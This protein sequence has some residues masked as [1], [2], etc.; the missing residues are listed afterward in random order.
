MGETLIL[1]QQGDPVVVEESV[2]FIGI[3]SAG[4]RDAC[5]RLVFPAVTTPELPPLVYS[6]FG[7]CGNPT[8]TLNLDN[9][10]LR[11]P[12]VSRTLTLGGTRVTRFE[13]GEGDVIVT[14]IW[15]GGQARA[16]LT[17]A[18]FRQFYDYLA[19]SS[20]LGPTDFITWEPRDRNANVYQVELLSLTVGSGDADSHFDVQDFRDPGGLDDGGSIA[21]ALDDANVLPTGYVDREMELRMRIVGKVE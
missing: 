18:L 2:T 16:S 21:N 1:I 9:D 14:E 11:H 4:D 15:E 10:V 20:L 3:G 6:M 8:R 5:R 17:T 12:Y 19:N 7:L 13:Q